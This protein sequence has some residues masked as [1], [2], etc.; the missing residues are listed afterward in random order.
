M[1]LSARNVLKGTVKTIKAGP[2][3]AEVVVELAPGLQ[4]ASIITKQ[5]C[6]NLGLKKGKK[7]FVIVKASSVMVGVE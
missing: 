6:K 1:K 3:N 4:I 7:A 2:I 5:S